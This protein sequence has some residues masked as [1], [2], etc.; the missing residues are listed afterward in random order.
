[1]AHVAGHIGSAIR[2]TRDLST[3]ICVWHDGPVKLIASTAHVPSDVMMILMCLLRG[4][5]G[6]LLSAVSRVSDHRY[7]LLGIRSGSRTTGRRV[8]RPTSRSDGVGDGAPTH[9]RISARA[10][11]VLNIDDHF[12]VSFCNRFIRGLSD[13]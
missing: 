4:I 2:G 13:R 12:L 6:L 1:M 7:P 9:V 5:C 11:P 10:V 3:A 8:P